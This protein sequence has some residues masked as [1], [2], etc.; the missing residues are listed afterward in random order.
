MRI[1]MAL[2]VG[3]TLATVLISAHGQY[4]ALE[5]QAMINRVPS[6][7]VLRF[8]AVVQAR[9][10]VALGQPDLPEMSTPVKTPKIWALPAIQRDR[11]G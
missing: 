3:A 8:H 6:A 2:L 11:V 7:E 1:G 4:D 9:I 10:D 5:H